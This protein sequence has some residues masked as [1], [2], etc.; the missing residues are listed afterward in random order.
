MENQIRNEAEML[1]ALCKEMD[2][3]NAC[4]MYDFLQKYGIDSYRAEELIKPLIVLGLVTQNS[5]DYID[6]TKEGVEAARRLLGR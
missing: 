1:I 5:I 2:G 3:N 6:I 4:H